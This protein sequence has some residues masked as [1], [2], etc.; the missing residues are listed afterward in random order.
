MDDKE[1][2]YD[3]HVS[4]LMQQLV[5]VC[6]EHGIPMFAKFQ[7]QDEAFCTTALLKDGHHLLTHL[8][9]LGQC[10]AGDGVNID[11]Y[12]NWVA[13]KA[14]VEG[15]SSTYLLL[16]GVP[17]MPTE[18]PDPAP[19]AAPAPGPPVAPNFPAALPS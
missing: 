3:E 5:A 11:K 4:P 1:K 15:H 19:E 9:V 6:Q 7:F 10:A 14:R 18:L 12:L 13:R 2:L 16:A 17:L 8:Q